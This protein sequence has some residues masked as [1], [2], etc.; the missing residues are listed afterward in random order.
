MCS[1]CKRV[2]GGTGQ[3]TDRQGMNICTVDNPLKLMY[4]SYDVKRASAWSSGR[5]IMAAEHSGVE[6]SVQWAAGPMVVTYT[7]VWLK[8]FTY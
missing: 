3:T 1:V 6:P 7:S 8:S 2:S 5:R 4:D